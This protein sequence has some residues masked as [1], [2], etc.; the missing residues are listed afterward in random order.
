M[1]PREKLSQVPLLCWDIYSM[2]LIEQARQ[3]KKQ[4]EI[5]ILKEYQKKF[6]WFFDLDEILNN[7]QFEVLIL[8]N[9][10]QE[11]QWVNKGFSKMTGYPA[12]YAI[13]KTP[14]FL[15]GEATSTSTLKNIRQ[16]LKSG[17]Q[18]KDTVINY[19]KNGEIYNCD[20]EIY[21]IKDSHS[22]TMHFLALENEI[23]I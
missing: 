14:H 16:N 8:T 6:N 5:D 12:N 20:I 23:A 1:K 9:L 17:I 21:P 22:S 10:K 15:Q 19:R 11:I 13:G 4:S 3:F 7:N 2:Y 18:F